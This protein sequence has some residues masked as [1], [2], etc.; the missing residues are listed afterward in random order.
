MH[1]LL[2]YYYAA[3][4]GFLASDYF[5]GFNVRIAFL[6]DWPLARLA[7]YAMCFACLAIMILRPDWQVLVSAAES[8]MAIIALTLAMGVRV[9][10]VSDDVLESGRKLVTTQEILNYLISG[11]VAYYAWM[12]AIR[13]LKAPKRG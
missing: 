5:F 3:T 8:L 12:T 13:R 1:R 6:D 7:Y 4:L 2:T 11:S 9:M 10:V